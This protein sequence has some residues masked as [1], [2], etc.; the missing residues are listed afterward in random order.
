MLLPWLYCYHGCAIFTFMCPI[1]KNSLIRTSII[2][3]QI[4]EIRLFHDSN[5]AERFLA[6]SRSLRGRVI[7]GWK[8][9]ETKQNGE[10]KRKPRPHA[11]LRSV[12]AHLTTLVAI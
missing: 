6:F 3:Y 11:S 2:P 12:S 8:H 4:L 1:L 5:H 10:T 9:L 7:Y